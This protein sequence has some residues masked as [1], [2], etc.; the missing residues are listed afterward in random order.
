MFGWEYPPRFSGGLGVACKGLV[1]GLLAQGTL[2]RVVLPHPPEAVDEPGLE[3]VDAND[4]A[5][6]PDLG[7]GSR[8]VEVLRIASPLHPYLDEAGY[9]VE[10][11]E[12]NRSV[13]PSSRRLHGGY[14]A[15]L[16]EEVAR[17]A[18][19]S[20][21]LV[22]RQAIDFDVIHAHDWMTF[23]AAQLVSKISGRPFVAHVHAT[24]YDRTGGEGNPAIADIERAGVHAAER[25]VCVS[26]YTAS[27]VRDRYGVS[28]K[29]LRVVYN[30]T[31]A[32]PESET[33]PRRAK[34][35]PV[36][37]FAGRLTLQKGPD[38]FVEAARLALEVRPDARFVLVG[39]GDMKPRLLRRV[40]QAGLGDRILFT[41]FLP[42]EELKRLY[43]R[44]DVYVLPSVS[45]PF[46]LTV[47]E[48]LRQGTP[49][50]LSRKAGVAEVVRHALRVDF[51]NV[52]EL[53]GK[54]LSVLKFAPLSSE[55]SARGRSEV[56][57]LTWNAAAASCLK[58]YRE[59]L[60]VPTRAI[61][62]EL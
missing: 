45:E 17:Y 27:V 48:S 50:I 43:R 38:Y 2:V 22:R 39:E 24:E 58:I 3:F 12:R 37:L 51:W 15:G 52:R 1:R 18:E 46:G 60:P 35:E 57:R 10:K 30:A 21:E 61:P 53:A 9:R 25:V 33:S 6:E 13:P 5:T 11:F 23:P 4:L 44:A 16:H 62:E 8:A 42:P 59:L 34:E 56:G 41:G 19:V 14:G 32:D 49:V 20:T 7:I 29:K 47:L 26:R 40:A 54:I 36:I 55:L 31:D 28:E